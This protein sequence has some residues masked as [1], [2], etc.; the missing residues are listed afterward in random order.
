MVKN[1][2]KIVNERLQASKIIE[3]DE[4]WKSVDVDQNFHHF[5]RL[6]LSCEQE[7]TRFQSARLFSMIFAA[8]GLLARHR[9]AA[10]PASRPGE[11]LASFASWRPRAMYMPVEKGATK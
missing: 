7:S 10:M 11:R 3:N 4:V 6:S 1:V 5:P 8:W 2:E 9:A